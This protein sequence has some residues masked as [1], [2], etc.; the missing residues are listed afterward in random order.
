MSAPSMPDK[1]LDTLGILATSSPA[2]GSPPCGPGRAALVLGLRHPGQHQL[3]DV[4]SIGL[5]EGLLSQAGAARDL[6]V[7]DRGLDPRYGGRRDTQLPHA[8]AGEH[9][10]GK[11][12]RRGL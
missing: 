2:R 5:L 1:L 3:A 7:P 8:Q 4:V 11:L 9:G 6:E 12:V 10:D